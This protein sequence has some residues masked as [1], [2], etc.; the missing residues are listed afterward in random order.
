MSTFVIF[1]NMKTYRYSFLLLFILLSGVLFAQA[2]GVLSPKYE[3]RAVWVTTIENLDWPR[4]QIK[5]PSDVEIQKGEFIRMLDSLRALNVN[6]IMVQTR[7]RGDLLYPSKIEP[8]SKVLTGVPGA[9]PGYDPLA[10][11]IDECHKRG[12][13]FHAWIVTLPLG[14]VQHVRELGP[15]ALKNRKP[16]LCSVHKGN[17]YMEPGEPETVD[18]LS[19]LVSEIVENYDVDGIHLD[20]VRYPD[21]PKGYPDGYLYKRYGKGRQLADWRRDNITDIVRGIYRK[22]KLLKPWVRVSCAPIGRYDD[23]HFYSSRGYNAR[24]TVY[25]EAQLWL[26]EGIVD[27]LF[28]M[29]YFSG[30]DF[31]PFVL[32]WLQNANGRHIAPGMANY[33]LLPE[34]GDWKPEELK[35]QLFTSRSAGAAGTVMFRARHLL[36]NIKGY[37]DI[38]I[39]A[40][41]YYVPVPPMAWYGS[42]PAVAPEA[43]HGVYVGD[44]LLLKWNRVSHEKGMPAYKY[45]VY[46]SSDSVVD[47]SKVENLIAVGLQDNYFSCRGFANNMRSWAVV[48]VDA[49]GVEGAAALWRDKRAKPNMFRDEFRLP[50]PPAWGME[51]VLR[52]AAG[53]QLYKGKYRERIGVRGLPPG[54]Y[55]FEIVTRNGAVVRR[56]PFSR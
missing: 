6:T 19:N 16:Q 38:Y 37:S 5:K 31:Y 27:A 24:R 44:S 21:S 47:I 55:I 14:N 39:R 10:F 54:I 26:D 12:M 7:V 23:L 30:N 32:D 11:M 40:N 29:V 9:N 15:L 41:D 53:A 18:Y 2:E 56:V 52:D 49:Y 50:P 25:Q 22:V 20:Y 8:F 43:F 45:N 33:R 46:A 4:T 34:Y 3:Y 13:Q 36:D 42:V 1:F 35:R 48:A 51:V 17:W 28:P